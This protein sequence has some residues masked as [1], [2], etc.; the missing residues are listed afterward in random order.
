MSRL[1]GDV[2]GSQA[3]AGPPEST[4]A[5]GDAFRSAVEAWIV[6]D[7][8]EA[9]AA[10]LRTLLAAAD[11]PALAERFADRLHFGT[12]GLRGPLR[13]GPAGMNRAVV[14]RA[15]AG[16]A[17]YLRARNCHGPVVIGY[18]ARHGSNRFALDTAEIMAG[19]GFETLLLPAALPTP[20]LSFAV[21][22]FRASAG[23]MVTAS[24]NPARDNGYKVYLGGDAVTD[25]AADGAQIVP[26]VDGEVETAIAA[27][28]RL[29]EVRRA[30]TWRLVDN[31]VTD[32]YVAA[33]SALVAPGPRDIRIAY[34]ALHGVG[35]RVARRVF[36]RAGFTVVA[37]VSEQ[38]EPDP[39]FP[40]VAFPNPE[41]PGVMNLV[42]DLARRTGANI[43]I[44]NDPDA[45][46]CAVACGERMLTG[47]ELGVLLGDHL[48]ST[49]VRGR[50]ASTV[51]SSS[52]LGRIC[53]AHGIDYAETLTGFKWI[54]RAGADL[55]YGFEESL[56]YC[57]APALTRDKDGISAAARAAELAASLATQGKT[58]LD[59]LDE[60][61]LEYGVHATAQLSVRVSSPSQITDQMRAL[62]A[63]PP[64]TL[65]GVPVAAVEDLLP[66]ADVLRWRA[67]GDCL[68]VVI[69]PSGTEPK[70]KVY[71]QV[72]EPVDDAGLAAARRTAG[73]RIAELRTELAAI[74]GI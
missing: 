41:E 66:E 10:E 49:G 36:E 37:S 9:D 48:L 63:E 58:L 13:A 22:H 70:L 6:D 53:A 65:A 69:R 71:L 29:A 74:L 31:A 56:G 15:A 40:T 55:A 43:A 60:L 34:T 26:P 72:I 27:V 14:G 5:P 57:V 28:D 52:M 38:S 3:L 20:V 45:D 23:I 16:L 47:D 18:D 44:A 19:A 7:P 4:A 54:V 11:W 39:D 46:R 32:A 68:R 59:R 51:V 67:V 24:H 1:S 8:S 42:L 30:G 21:R 64:T 12:A 62:R 73:E 50:F 17:A 61:S 33:V 35:E 25:P 2:P